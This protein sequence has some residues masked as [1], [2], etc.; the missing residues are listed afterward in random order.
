[1]NRNDGLTYG[2]SILRVDFVYPVSLKPNRRM[3]SPNGAIRHDVTTPNES[4]PDYKLNTAI[5]P[6]V[7]PEIAMT[8]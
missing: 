3:D 1:V 4:P 5:E 2:L 7:I 6:S 8:D